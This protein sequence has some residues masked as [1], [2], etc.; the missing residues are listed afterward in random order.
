MLKGL[1]ASSTVQPPLTM[2]GNTG[3][4]PPNLTPIDKVLGGESLAGLKTPIAIV[5]YA[6]M[7]IMQFLHTVGTATGPD[8]SRLMAQSQT[9]DRAGKAEGS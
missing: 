3:V 1:G 4:V 7:W 5:A 6:V 8:A 2:D 9:I